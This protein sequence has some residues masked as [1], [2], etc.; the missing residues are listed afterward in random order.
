[1]RAYG[2]ACHFIGI[3][4]HCRSVATQAAEYVPYGYRMRARSLRD[5]HAMWRLW[6]DLLLASYIDEPTKSIAEIIIDTKVHI[7]SK[8]E[9]K[10]LLSQVCVSSLFESAYLLTSVIEHW[11]R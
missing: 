10:R 5:A 2:A 4:M 3:N 11:G 7:P 1:M 6:L 8:K 9:M